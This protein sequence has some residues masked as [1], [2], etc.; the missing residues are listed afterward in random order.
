[1]KNQGDLRLPGTDHTA[2][3]EK[4]SS[5]GLG[6][7]QESLRERI[8]VRKLDSVLRTEETSTHPMKNREAS[9][10]F[11]FGEGLS[12]VTSLPVT[13]DLAAAQA[14]RRGRTSLSVE[15]GSRP[16]DLNTEACVADNSASNAS[17]GNTETCKKVSLLKQHDREH[18]SKFVTSGGSGLDLNAEDVT[19][20]MN[21]E[22]FR[23]PKI[24]DHL[25]SRRDASECG[26]TT[27]PVKGKDSLR[28]WKEMKQ[29][30]FLSSSHGGISIQRGVTSF[31]HGGIPMPKQRGRKS[32]NDILKKKMELA[33]KEQVDRF[34][35]IAAPS[36]LLNGLNPGIINHVRNKKQV[37]SII[38]ALV[39]SEKLENG[40][41]ETKET[42]NV[43]DSGVHLLSFSRG[44]GGST[45]LSGNK[46]IGGCHI[47][48]G[49]SDSS[50]VGTICGRNSVIED[51]TLALKLSTSSKL[52][53]ESRTFSNEESTNV[54]SISSLSVRAA[55]VASQWLE[56]LHQDIKGRLSALRRSKKRVRAVITTE[57][58]FL[59]SKEFP[60]NQENDPFIMKTSSDG[61]SSNAMSSLHQARW[62]TLFDQMDKALIEEEKQLE[63]W[64]NQV[65]EMQLHCDQGLQN[66]Q[67][68][69]ISVSQLQETSENYNRKVETF[70]REIAVRAAAAS[71]YSTC[72]FLMS[73]EN[74]SCF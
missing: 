2:I 14:E 10:Q 38:E 18:D 58:P 55:S 24:H 70:E 25:K 71:I 3:G 64:L 67:W 51:D 27:S 41:V 28:V 19:S 59:I 13:I 40:C 73:K 30:G 45:I 63:S 11:Q 16:L 52:S 33:K 1:M 15:A 42:R 7:K 4:R 32:K 29:N 26:S 49:E 48:T 34:T 36:G 46:Q 57:L 17:P 56:L 47:L 72:S 68:N 74:V 62:S 60:S 54:N 61:Q 8:K 43:G 20:P 69:S 53:E 22:L 5:G 65:K 6:E 35:K 39:K 50:M 9:D 31:S 37:H 66:F 44:N 12:Q 23:N 21:A